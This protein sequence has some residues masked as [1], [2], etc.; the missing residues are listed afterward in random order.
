MASAD[1]QDVCMISHLRPFSPVN[2][3]F[4]EEDSVDFKDA[5]SFNSFFLKLFGTPNVLFKPL[6]TCMCIWI[7]L[8]CPCLFHKK[9]SR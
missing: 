6:M 9:E 8:Y 5:M 3:I 1:D 4:S 2:G 7:P